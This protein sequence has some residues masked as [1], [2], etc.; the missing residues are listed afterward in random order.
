MKKKG[1]KQ[2]PIGGVIDRAGSAR[3]YKTGD[4]RTFAPRV[5]LEKCRH[6][7]Q[8]WVFCPDG[9][10]NVEDGKMTGFDYDYCKGCGICA[11]VCPVDCITM[12]EEQ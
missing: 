10:V 7:L 3:D 11:S 8:C 12:E 9:S 2:I 1:W 4:W 5:D 6:C